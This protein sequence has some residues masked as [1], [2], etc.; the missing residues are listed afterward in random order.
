MTVSYS[1]FMNGETLATSGVTGTPSLTTSATATSA[2]GGYP[3]VAAPGTLAAVNYTFAFVNGTLTVTKATLTVSADNVT[4]AYGAANPALTVS[5]GGFVNGDTAASLTTPPTVS[6]PATLTSAVGT[7]PITVSGAVSANYTISYVPGMLTVNKAAV[8]VSA[9]AT[10]RAWGGESGVHGVD[11]GFVNSET[12]A[13][14]GV[15]GAPSLTTTATPAS[16]VGGYPIVAAPGTLAA[17][18]YSFTF[19]SGTLTVNKATLTVSADNVTKAYG[20]ANPA[21]TVS[22][23]GFVNGDTAASLTAPPTVS[24]PATLTSAVGTYPITASGAV[25]ANYAISYVAGTLTVTKASV[26][27]TAADETKAYGAANPALTVSY[28]GFV[29]GETLATSGVTGA[30]SLT[31]PATPT[32]AVGGYPIVAAPGT[33]AAA[34]YSFTFV[35]GTLTVN[36]ATLTVSADNVTKA[37]GAANPALTVSYGGF[38]NGDTAA[39][40]T[41]PPTVSTP[42]TLTSAVG[43]YPITAS[44]AVSANYAISYVAGTLTV[45]KASVTVTAADETKA[46]GAANPALTVSYSGFVNGET[47]ATS[48]I[49]GGPSLTTTATA[50]S[51]VGGYP[52]VAAPGTLAA[53]NYSFTFVSGT[54]TVNKATLTVSADNVTKAYGAANPALTVSYGGFVNGDTAASLTTPPTVS[55]TATPTSAVGTYP[56]TVS[57][58]VSANYTISYVPGMLTVNK[59]AVT[60]SADAT[61]RA[62]GAANPAFTASYSGFVNGETL[63]TSGVTGAPS[64][65]TPATPT[66]AVGGYP[67]VAALGTLAAANYSFTFVSG[68]LTV[69]KATL[70]VSADNVTKAYGAANPALTVSYGGFVN[71]D[72]AAS[73]TAPPTVSTPATL[74]SAV[75][76]YPITASG[77]VSANYAI[78]YVAG[79]LTVTKASVTV[80]AAD[81]TKAYGAANPALTVSYS[82]FVNGE[83]LATSG[84]SGGPSLTTTATATSAVGGYPIVAAPGTLAAANYSFTFVSGTLTVNKAT[85]TVSADNVTKAYG[86]ANPAL[87]VSYGG[88]VNGDTAASLTTPPTVSTTATPTSAVGTYPITVSG[89]V[90]ANY[91][92]GYVS[93]TLTV[94]PAV[95]TVTAANETKAYGAALPTLTVSYSGFAN[96]DTAASLTTPPTVSTTATPT[97]AVGTYPI[98]ASG[99][100]SAN[101]AISY[102]AGTLTITKAS[103][104]VTAADETKAY[105]AALPTLT[106]SYS[107]FVNGDTVASLTTPPTVSTT[108]TPTSAVGTYPI[109]ASGAVSANYTISYLSGTLTVAP[110]ALTVTAANETKAYGGANPALTVS[111]SGFVNGDTV[112]SLTT[113]PT[114]STPATAASAVGTYPIT[115]S[116]AVSANYTISYVSGTLTVTPAVLTVTA[117]NETKAYGAANPA[118]TVSYSGFVNGDTAASLTTAPTVSTPAT[119]A[120]AVGTYPITASGAVSANYTISYVSGTLTVT[121]AMLTV[122]VANQTKAYGAALPT[123]TVNY[124][125]FANGDTA[126]SLTTPPTISTTATIASAVGTYPITASGAVSANYAISYVAGTLSIT[127]ASVTVTADNQAKPYGAANP[128]LTVSYSGF[129]NGDT[130]ASLTTAPTVSTPATAASAVGTYPIT[131]SG[132]VSANYAISYMAGTLTVTKASLTVT[133]A[134]ETKAYGAALPTLT[135]SYSGFAN[136]DTAA[137]LTTAPTVSTPATAASAVGTYP[138]TASGA[139]SANYTMSYV[140][141]TLTVTPAML[142]VTVA[143]QTKAYGAAL[144]TLTVS[145]SGFVNGDTVASLTTAPTVSTP[146]T[147]ASAVGTYPITASGAVSA[148]YTISYVAGTLTITKAS[149]TVTAD[150]QVKPY[151]AANPALTVSY[152][153]FVNGDTVASLT[154]APTVSTPATAASAV[155]TYP[156]TAS[157]AVSGNYTIGYVSGTLTVTPAVLTVTAANET[158]AYGAANPALTVSYSGFVNGDTAASLTSAPTVSTPATAASAVGTYPITASGAVSANYTI[159]YVSGTLTVTPAVLTVTATTRRRPTARRIRR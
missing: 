155:G 85:L 45:T 133:A 107:G 118:L 153:G 93:G 147:T 33:L 70:T 134:D 53:A 35:S 128:T 55:T 21:L 3:I 52:I 14:S 67:I 72:T 12:L 43:T 77:A 82:G 112:A 151:G 116:G 96:G 122:T 113:A 44:G 26:T 25:S 17:A 68:T 78:S 101:Y 30:P 75:G 148:N 57:G 74:T 16:A 65:T 130:A 136:G 92:I 137:S 20:A 6:T 154:T 51:A 152:S 105:G 91:T 40:L 157:G 31:T 94:T 32:S 95:L 64:L 83:T 158:K 4:K 125:G 9:D 59:A 27:V 11:S 156:I 110:A 159:S 42:A 13:T 22:Y 2:L 34:N 66:S 18:N 106:V 117:A 81:E 149:V 8:T 119:A 56:I 47:L 58:A 84:I 144:P 104:T 121:P 139:V 132:A 50:T 29:N 36:K 19:V 71:G 146:A 80:T 109:T 48:G 1:G 15:T 120:S 143:N 46:Y 38:V 41:A 108:A 88:F 145:Y 140:A 97:S 127:K 7:Y 28:S 23:G 114:V 87:T 102:V 39:S 86:A 73:L 126:A 89:A 63:A 124:S 138:I 131:A 10:A 24:T 69:N 135:V 90:S 141:G 103:V 60:V 49:S 98:T 115:A 142:T 62:Y 123:L 100:V 79:T 99:A 37:Y 54:L 150:N 111:Y 5:Y 76:T 129:A 61:A